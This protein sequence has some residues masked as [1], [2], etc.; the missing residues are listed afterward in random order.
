MNVTRLRPDTAELLTPQECS[1]LDRQ[2]RNT[3][4]YAVFTAVDLWVRLRAKPAG[5][6]GFARLRLAARACRRLH[7]GAALRAGGSPAP[8]G[9]SYK[10]S[11][12]AR[13]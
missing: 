11:A 2:V 5:T 7:C 13:W 8:L 9:I 10:S 4:R 1:F 6:T 12:C 3:G